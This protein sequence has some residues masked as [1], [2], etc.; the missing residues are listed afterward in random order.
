MTIRLLYHDPKSPGG[1][2]PFDEAILS[3]AREGELKLACPYISLDYLNRVINGTS[4]RL[5][6]DIQ[7]WLDNQASV[8]RSK[9]VEFLSEHHDS[10]RNYPRLHAKVVIGSQALMFGSANFTHSGILSRAEV[11]AIIDDAAQVIELTAWFEACWDDAQEVLPRLDAI[12]DY[13]KSLPDEPAHARA[14]KPKL[15][16]SLPTKPAILAELEVQQTPAS[17][18]SEQP[19]SQETDPEQALP[20]SD[21]S[22]DVTFGYVTP[23]VDVTPATVPTTNIRADKKGWWK[24]LVGG[25]VLGLQYDGSP[26]DTIACRK[27]GKLLHDLSNTPQQFTPGCPGTSGK[28]RLLAEFQQALVNA[29]PETAADVRAKANKRQ[30]FLNGPKSR[31]ATDSER[32][33]IRASIDAIP[34]EW[35][36][37]TSR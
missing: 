26:A 25:V 6:T 18:A 28:R 19:T 13:A 4:W 21:T 27:Y 29:S 10:V 33:A 31:Y 22:D 32:A 12:A 11:S 24:S 35:L 7:E 8:A 23:T 1:V 14:D 9:I 5:L 3:I 15:F 30:E 37:E 36:L 2:S 17:E 16:P 34:D 20:A